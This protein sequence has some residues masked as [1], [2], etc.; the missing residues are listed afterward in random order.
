MEAYRDIQAEASW[1]I[2]VE[3]KPRFLIIGVGSGE[4]EV[5][6]RRMIAS[7]AIKRIISFGFMSS[8][9]KPSIHFDQYVVTTNMQK[10]G[11]EEGT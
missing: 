10:R 7:R 8:L 4:E 2:Y 3:K 6:S 9:V 5:D 1:I 11:I